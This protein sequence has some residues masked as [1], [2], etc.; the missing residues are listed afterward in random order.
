MSIQAVLIH[1][2]FQPNTDAPAMEHPLYSEFIHPTAKDM[3]GRS[4]LVMLLGNRAVVHCKQGVAHYSVTPEDVQFMLRKE[5]DCFSCLP[6]LG[7]A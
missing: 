4:C 3:R 1:Y 5:Y 2:G 6:V 7:E